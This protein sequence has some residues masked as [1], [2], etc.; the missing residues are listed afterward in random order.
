MTA[1]KR[2]RTIKTERQREQRRTARE[3]LDEQERRNRYSRADYPARDDGE[4][5]RW[6]P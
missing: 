3:R 6:R 2:P 5:A 4:P 1:S